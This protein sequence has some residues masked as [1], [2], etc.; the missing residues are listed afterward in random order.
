MPP[1][2][3]LFTNTKARK[4]QTDKGEGKET[5]A[6]GSQYASDAPHHTQRPIATLFAR[7]LVRRL[8]CT[9]PQKT[10]QKR[11][12]HN[13]N[14]CILNRDR[15]NTKISQG[16]TRNEPGVGGQAVKKCLYS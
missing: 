9:F 8:K 2:V 16:W 13:M 11:G 14:F 6:D 10:S 5:E 7:L 3:I 4:A 1:K 15:R 12:I